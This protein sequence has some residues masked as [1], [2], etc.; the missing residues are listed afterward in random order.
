MGLPRV[1]KEMLSLP[2]ASFLE[3]AVLDCIRR[4][5]AK[6]RGVR[7]GFDRA[8]N[9]LARYQHGR[10]SPRPLTFTA[11]TDH[12]GF[13]ALRMVDGHTLLAAFRGWVE[14]E[15]FRGAKVRFHSGR[16][17]VRGRVVEVTRTAVIRGVAGRRGRPEE[18]RV[19]VAAPVAA[20]AP[21][22]WDLPAARV[23]GGRVYA[24]ACDDLAGC[25]GLV[26]LL[27]RL[28]ATGARADILC[29]FTRAEE[30]GFVGAMA[31]AR[32]GSIPRGSPVI[33]IETSRMGP[34][35][36]PGAGP[37]L[38]VG[39]R[40]SVFTPALTAYCER[41]ARD[42]A[43]RRRGFVFQRKLMDGGTC[44][45]TA[46]LAY[47]YPASGI[48]L[49]LGNYHNMDVRRRRIASEYIDLRDW[50]RMVEWFE[51]LAL[52]GRDWTEEPKT[53]RRTLEERFGKQVAWLT[54]GSAGAPT[55]AL[56]RPRVR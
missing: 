21:G 43:Q 56:P 16:E 40:A 46:Y 8:G 49:A 6:L 30:V 15:Y 4:R 42:L 35:A 48:C 13:A 29:L 51:A 33:A 19:R 47:G 5:C 17:W 2:T 41:V 32:L 23:R 20:G 31:A 22:M 38:R 14:P 54:T 7:V 53:M 28:S 3:G 50:R 44:E 36:P 12:P 52:D 39:D 10:R 27:E 45:S 24:R 34:H 1:L 11:H 25:A 18:V 26:T 55:P 9:L 37:I